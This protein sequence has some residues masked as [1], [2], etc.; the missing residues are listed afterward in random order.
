MN[1]GIFDLNLLIVFDAVMRE[2][3]VTRAGQSIGLSQPAMSHALNRLRYMLKDDLF[4]RTPDGMVPTTRAEQLAQPL[5]RALS[6][7]QLALEP[8]TFV[9]EQAT[10]RFALAV[11]N[12]AAVVLS[13]PLV[14]AV[15]ERAPSVRLD[16]RPSGTL[17]VVELLDRGE[18]D[19]A[20]GDLAHP[21][22]RFAW[23]AL[24][25]DPFVLAMR[26]GHPAGRRKLSAEQFAQ[27]AH[28]EIS[29]SG[30]DTGFIDRWLAGRGLTRRIAHR[31]PYLSAA[32]ILARSD[33]VATLSRR[34]AEAFLHRE[35]LQ[36][37]NLPCSS[38]QVSIGSSGIADW[39]IS[40]LTAG[41]VPSSRRSASASEAI[42]TA[43][44]GPHGACQEISL[45]LNAQSV[46]GQHAFQTYYREENAFAARR[47]RR[48]LRR[49]LHARWRNREAS[50]NLRGIDLNLLVIFDALMAERSITRTAKA[51]GMTPSAVSH[52]LHR[53]R[54]TFNDP[55]IERTRAGMVPTQRARDLSKYVRAALQQLQRGVAQQLNFDPATSERRFNIRISDFMIGCLLPRL[56]ARVRAEA[57]N[58]TLVVEHLPSDD[59]EAYALGDIQLRV[60]ADARRSEYEQ[61][62]IWNDPFVIAMR[63]DHPAAKCQMTL[64]RYVGLPHLDISSAIIDT[65]TLDEVLNSKG[66]ARRA[67]VTIPSLAGVIPILERTDL[68]AI[69][70]ERWLRLYAEPGKL[71]T[72]PLPLSGVEYAV[73]MVWHSRDNKEAGHSWLR[74]LIIEEFAALYAPVSA[75][76]RR[77][78]GS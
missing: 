13:P 55:L 70:P 78:T 25:Q 39:T 17:D 3:N 49:V 28:L 4:V 75:P 18:L 5:R 21:G 56:C 63:R 57:P 31:A 10:R 68:C 52:A 20:T 26:R 35:A 77:N 47:N 62:R 53:L 24:L 32:A 7:M 12:Y 40:R 16:I 19:L 65:R 66:L 37:R 30:E 29:S 27:L 2:R 51:I 34:I 59:R 33:M 1:W 71:A 73:D 72:A 64:D 44:R 11:N 22:E 61:E 48:H 74:R 36:I 45:A 42:T 6:D 43:C 50:M 76:S 60:D 38:P 14:M 67:I 58:V 9:P 23:L 8:E 69:L 54:S 15:A 46:G 41:F